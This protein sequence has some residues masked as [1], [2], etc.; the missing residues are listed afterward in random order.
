MYLLNGMDKLI[1][2]SGVKNGEWFQFRSAGYYKIDLMVLLVIP[3]NVNHKYAWIRVRDSKEKKVKTI[4]VTGKDV[5]NSG[6]GSFIIKAEKNYSIKITYEYAQLDT[7][8]G[9]EFCDGVGNTL[10]ITKIS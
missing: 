6:C 8:M 9:D 10:L 3:P 2:T 1:I 7:E 5:Y 4:A